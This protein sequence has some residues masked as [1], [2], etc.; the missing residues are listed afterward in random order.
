MY[1]FFSPKSTK[2]N[3]VTGHMANVSFSG[4]IAYVY[5]LKQNTSHH[6]L[7]PANV[8]GRSKKLVYRQTGRIGTGS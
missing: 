7:S 2:C 8:I 4:Q 6:V 1:G 3:R 5:F